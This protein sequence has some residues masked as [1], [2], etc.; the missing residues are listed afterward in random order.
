MTTF[1]VLLLPV[2]GGKVIDLTPDR[3]MSY[4]DARLTLLAIARYAPFLHEEGC[5]SFLE[6]AAV[7]GETR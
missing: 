5:L 6:I 2:R 1:H 7:R 3:D 4:R